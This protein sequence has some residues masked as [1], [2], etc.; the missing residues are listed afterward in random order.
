MERRIEDDILI[1]VFNHG[2][3]NSIN[4]EVLK[5]LEQTLDELDANDS[6]KGLILTG[7]GRFFSSG[8]HLPT[9]TSFSSPEDCLAWFRYEEKVLSK[10]FNM[11]KPVVAAINGHAVAGGL[12]YS[13]ACDYRIAV[14]HPKVRIGM[15]EIKIGLALAPVMAEVMR[16]GLG[17][18]KNFKDIIF[19]GEMIN[20][21]RAY[22]MGI[23]DQLVDGP[24]ELMAEA[25]KRIVS[26]IDTPGRPFMVLKYQLRRP[27]A[28]L[29]ESAIKEYDWDLLPKTFF[30]EQVVNTLK[31]VQATM[32]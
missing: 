11:R 19:A 8:F 10:L 17:T 20:P 3:T 31:A 13:M 12:I 27:F 6:L 7:N 2:K 4:E 28:Q 18:V 32:E 14:S 26:L 5:G 22:E 15:S 24:E 1:A 25:K 29:I 9:F 16:F 30:N 23:I 21:V